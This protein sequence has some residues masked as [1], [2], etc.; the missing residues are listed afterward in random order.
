MASVLEHALKRQ[1]HHPSWA[2]LFAAA[3]RDGSGRLEFGEF[4]GLVRRPPAPHARSPPG[5]GLDASRLSDAHLRALW[6]LADADGGG[7]LAAGEFANF[8]KS[9]KKAALPPESRATVCGPEKRTRTRKGTVAPSWE[10]DPPVVFRGVDAK[11][12]AGLV[13]HVKLLDEDPV[14]NGGGAGT[15]T[16]GDD[17]LGLLTLPLAGLTFA[18]PLD[19]TLDLTPLLGYGMTEDPT[20]PPGLGALRVRVSLA[21]GGHLLAAV[22]YPESADGITSARAGAA[23]RVDSLKPTVELDEFNG[24]LAGLQRHG[25]VRLRGAV[26]ST[27]NGLLEP[28]L[29]CAFCGLAGKPP[30]V[31][32][33]RT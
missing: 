6:D 16:D 29:T 9:C 21:T 8:V 19:A 10:G 22:V 12:V 25:G 33:P 13:L 31:R 28:Q 14:V 7:D 4:L 20:A 17:G 24:W 23:P 11:D 26:P 2:R 18:N 1:P 15:A 5:L 27:V 32:L 3:D 30:W